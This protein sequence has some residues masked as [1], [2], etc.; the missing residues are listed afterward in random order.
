MR[1]RMRSRHG[2]FRFETRAGIDAHAMN[3]LQFGNRIRQALNEGAHLEPNIS[4]R[5]RA[6]REQA[7]AR[8]RFETSGSVV[9]A[10]NITGRFG[11]MAGLSLRLLLPLIV[12]ATSLFAIRHWQQTQRVA[13]VVEIDSSV[14]AGDLPLDAYLDKGFEAWL[15]KHGR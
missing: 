8:Q 10:D 4:E 9:W 1:W 2:A 7:L 14:L 12:V 15:K 11:G 13:E 6:A 5:L 3:E